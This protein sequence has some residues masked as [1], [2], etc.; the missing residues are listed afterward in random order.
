MMKAISSSAKG[1]IDW[2]SRLDP[3]ERISGTS[4]CHHKLAGD[5]RQCAPAGMKSKY[6][7]REFATKRKRITLVENTGD[8]T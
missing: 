4:N 5:V 2:E 8:E 6:R 3:Y 7:K 1:D